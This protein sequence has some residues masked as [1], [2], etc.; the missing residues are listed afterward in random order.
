MQG[1]GLLTLLP[2]AGTLRQALHLSPVKRVL[3]GGRL[4]AQSFSLQRSSLPSSGAFLVLDCPTLIQ[5][6]CLILSERDF[7]SLLVLTR[8]SSSPQV[9]CRI[10]CRVIY[11]GLVLVFYP[12]P[13]GNRTHT[14][15]EKAGKPQTE[16]PRSKGIRPESQR[17]RAA[18]SP[19]E[20]SPIPQK[21]RP[22]TR[23]EAPKLYSDGAWGSSRQQQSLESL[24]RTAP[25]HSSFSVNDV[26]VEKSFSAPSQM[27]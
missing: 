10:C 25:S 3:S 21:H 12:H 1:S 17:Q 14:P 18:Q 8:I 2:L 23:P 5:V 13:N 26:T 20:T 11:V 16:P 7:G 15:E 19:Q 22:G 27:P 6:S 24:P 9:F 4:K